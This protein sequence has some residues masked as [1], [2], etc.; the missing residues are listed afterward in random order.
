V[1]TSRTDGS[2]IALYRVPPPPKWRRWKSAP[3][4]GVEIVQH[5]HRYVVCWPSIHPEGRVYVWLEPTGEVADTDH[6]PEPDDLTFLPL[7]AVDALLE[8]VPDLVA[9]DAVDF[10]L[11]GGT[12]SAAVKQ[13]L[14]RGLDVCANGDGA[15]RHDGTLPVVLRLVRAA[16]QGEPG[17]RPAVEELQHAFMAAVGPDRPGG[18]LQE[19]EFDDMLTGARKQVATTEPPAHRVPAA[20]NAGAA[21]RAPDAPALGND[22]WNARESLLRVRLAAHAQQCSAGFFL[23]VVLA[24]IA[25]AVPCELQLP[26]P[27]GAPR[28]LSLFVAGV[29]PPGVGKP[30]STTTP[31]RS[32]RS[33]SPPSRTSSRS[34]AARASSKPSSTGSKSKPPMA[35]PRSSRS[36]PGTARTTTWT[37]AKC[38]PN[39]GT[40]KARRSSRP[41][42]RCSLARRSA[43]PTLPATRAASSTPAATRSAS[44]SLSSRASRARSSTTPTQAHPSDS[45]GGTAP[46]RASPTKQRRGRRPS[47]GNHRQPKTSRRSGQSDGSEAGGSTK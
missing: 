31:G 19:H 3:V 28:P 26:V 16:E 23:E 38:S 47:N 6:V 41:S 18:Q 43:T 34:A 7:K 4:P 42:G 9:R 15:S 29:A 44:W 24:R 25:A 8:D 20:P 37:K 40:A 22:F 45:S 14:A 11:T 1:S 5:D 30:S 10:T 33:R 39:S 35:S 13:L 46:T 17:V 36:K 27:I 32:S 2:G 12:P 21:A